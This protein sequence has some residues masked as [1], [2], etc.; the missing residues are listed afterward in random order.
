MAVENVADRAA[1]YGMP[2]VIVDGNDVLAVH[3]AT[4]VAMERA[5]AGEGPTLMEC[6]TFRMTGHSAH[7]DARYVP[8]EMFEEWERKDPIIRYQQVLLDHG[9]IG[10]TELKDLHAKAVSE[11]D[12]AVEWAERNPFPDPVECL[13]GVYYR[14]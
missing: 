10:L 13:G 7:D 6:K 4:R 5:R 14:S 9:T 11:V 3:E 2:G 1:A 12:D 8:K